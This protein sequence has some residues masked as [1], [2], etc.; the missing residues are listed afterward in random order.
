MDGI[1]IRKFR[2][3]DFENYVD[4]L[5]LTSTEEYSNIGR[6]D[7][8]NMLKIMDQDWIWVTEVDSKAIGFITVQPEHGMMHVIWLDVHPTYQRMG[9][10]SALLKEAIQAGKNMGIGP[11]CV[12]VW[13]GNEKGMN[14]YSKYGFKKKKF[15]QNYY[16]NGLSAYEMVKDI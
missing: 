10:G 11:A 7:I 2:K 6:N 13:V 16:E 4:L 1:R 12:E 14:F 9:F 8:S 15:L 3:G 5:M